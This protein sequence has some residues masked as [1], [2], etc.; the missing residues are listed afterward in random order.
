MVFVSF[1]VFL[2]TWAVLDSILPNRIITT[3]LSIILGLIIFYFQKKDFIPYPGK[4]SVKNMN[5]IND[6]GILIAIFLA[7][8]IE[9]FFSSKYSLRKLEAL[10]LFLTTVA[11]TQLIL[12]TILRF[13]NQKK[14][15]A[16]DNA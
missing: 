4:T 1:T 14:N 5:S 7:I 6:N 16:N 15:K 12:T 8:L 3:I 13:T 11:I 10:L 2:I 9:D